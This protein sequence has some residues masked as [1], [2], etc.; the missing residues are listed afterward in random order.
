[1]SMWLLLVF[2]CGS[3]ED[4]SQQAKPAAIRSSWPPPGQA[5]ADLVHHA[6]SP[7]GTAKASPDN[8]VYRGLLVHVPFDDTGSLMDTYDDDPRPDHV[9]GYW[10]GLSPSDGSDALAW[11]LAPGTWV[12]A[13]SD[14]TV[15]Q[16]GDGAACGPVGSGTALDLRTPIPEVHVR[17][18]GVEP[19]VKIGDEVRAGD[20]LGRTM[21]CGSLRMGVRVG[22]ALHDPLGAHEWNSFFVLAEQDWTRLLA[23]T[24]YSRIGPLDGS[25]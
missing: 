20:R 5:V 23:P 16:E 7:R 10:P 13:P 11:R 9:L 15:V 12:L 4:A 1:M 18:T 22:G 6:E 2:A 19:I 14:G 24:P 25:F 17:M 21:D 3:A 8:N